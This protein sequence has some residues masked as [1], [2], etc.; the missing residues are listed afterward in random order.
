MP[1]IVRL[2]CVSPDNNNKFYN[3]TELGNGAW[4]AHWGRV[5]LEGN[6][7]VYPMSDWDKKY[8][9]KLRGHDGQPG[10]TDV[11]ELVSVQKDHTDGPSMK[12]A[13]ASAAVQDIVDFLLACARGVIDKNYTIAI[14]DVTQKQID[15]AQ[16]VLDGLAATS[17]KKWSRDSVNETLLSLYRIIPRKMKNTKLFLIQTNDDDPRTTLQKLISA[18]QDLLDVMHGQVKTQAQVVASASPE[19]RLGIDMREATRSEL[20]EIDDKTDF[21]LGS[22]TRVLRVINHATED[23]YDGYYAAN[24]TSRMSL[25]YHGSRN[26]NWWSILNAGLK[27]RPTNAV[28]TGSMFGDGLYFANKAKKSIGYTSLD[29]SRW[30]N[31]SSHKAYL[32]LYGVNVGRQWKIRHGDSSLNLSKVRQNGYDT[33]FAQG[34]ADLINDEIIAYEAERC[35]IKYLI[36]LKR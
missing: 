10:Y 34:G 13:G 19:M 16:D 29:G 12:V 1:R 31:G 7:K 21:S 14:A 25:L 8:Q 15:A 20:A 18:E 28:H 27:I 2:I 5:G 33:V 11:T 17:Q 23:A 4:E 30:A 3:M 32:A 36:E 22:S 26:E 35:T 24:A 9:E 6:K